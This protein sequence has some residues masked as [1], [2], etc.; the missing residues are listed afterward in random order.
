MSLLNF[1]I[2]EGLKARIAEAIDFKFTPSK[3]VP[4]EPQCAQ[5][6]AQRLFSISTGQE[7]HELLEYLQKGAATIDFKTESGELKSMVCTLSPTIAPETA[8]DWVNPSKLLTVWSVDRG[9][10]RT[11]RCDRIIQITLIGIL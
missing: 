4:F 5:V 8:S 9:G 3:E 6:P 10:W 2:P 7:K 1:E 11:I